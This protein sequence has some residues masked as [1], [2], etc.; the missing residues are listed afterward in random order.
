MYSIYL[1]DGEDFLTTEEVIDR[2]N[3]FSDSTLFTTVGQAMDYLI[4]EQSWNI[5]I[6]EFNTEEELQA[7]IEGYKFAMEGSI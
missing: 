5:D 6:K 7:F 3:I 4:Q 1:I 2:A